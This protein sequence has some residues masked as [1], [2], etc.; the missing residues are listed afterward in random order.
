MVHSATVGVMK[1]F[2][3][4]EVKDLAPAQLEGA[5]EIVRI[6]KFSKKALGNKFKNAYENEYEFITYAMTNEGFQRALSNFRARKPGV[7]TKLRSAW[8][9]FTVAVAKIV[10]LDKFAQQA[11]PL[12]A[13]VRTAGE[14]DNALL[15]VIDSVGDILT[16]PKAGVEV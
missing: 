14:L 11:K 15:R 7:Q 13:K 9:S 2:L 10:G 12:S 4:R 1:K 8:D 16:V 3:S 5:K 6:Y